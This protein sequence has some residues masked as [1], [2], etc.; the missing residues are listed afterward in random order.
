MS[1]AIHSFF[2]FFFVKGITE[3]W[4]GLA[5]TPLPLSGFLFSRADGGGGLDKDFPTGL[6][7]FLLQPLAQ[8]ADRQQSMRSFFLFF[9]PPK[10]YFLILEGIK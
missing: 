8:H 2:L 6:P 5:T 3:K 10:I 9:P 1:E 7:F 4:K